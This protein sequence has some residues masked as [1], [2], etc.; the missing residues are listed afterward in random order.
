MV[1]EGMSVVCSA[2]FITKPW[3]LSKWPAQ[4]AVWSKALPLTSSCLSPLPGS[5]Y[6]LGHERIMPVTC[7]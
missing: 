4:M 3:S 7:G 5:E 2:P 6:C 1:N